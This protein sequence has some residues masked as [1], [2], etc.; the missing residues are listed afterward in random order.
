MT[1]TTE[2]GRYLGPAIEAVRAR[3][4][5]MPTPGPESDGTLEWDGTTIVVVEVEAAGVVGLGYT[6]ADAS[7]QVVVESLLA[8]KLVG[9]DALMT[10]AL[11]TTMRGAVRNQG[12]VGVCAMAISAVD[13]ALWDLHAR[14]LD[15]PLLP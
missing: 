14:L 6:Y 5:R 3:A 10:P 11:F 2:T 8:K 12:T 1:T 15:L 4:Y 13:V 7:A 9:K